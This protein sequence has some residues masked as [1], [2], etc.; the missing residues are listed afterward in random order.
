MGEYS[1]NWGKQIL[2]L[3]FSLCKKGKTRED[4]SGYRIK[5]KLAAV[6]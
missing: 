1:V 6:I 4:S 2:M 3:T 5:V